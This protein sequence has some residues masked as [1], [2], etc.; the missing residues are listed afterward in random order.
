M[1]D[2]IERLRVIN[3]LRVALVMVLCISAALLLD[4]RTGVFVIFP[5]L[6]IAFMLHDESPMA[7]LSLVAGSLL[8]AI[9]SFVTID[10]FLTARPLFLL[11]TLIVTCILG[12]WAAQGFRGRWPWGFCALFAI[13]NV[14]G[15]AFAAI[16]GAELGERLALNWTLETALGVAVAWLVMLGIWPSPKTRDLEAFCEGVGHEC[17]VLLHKTADRIEAEQP[18]TYRPS[19]VSLMNFGKW[20]GQ[21]DSLK[22]RFT[23]DK[24]QHHA[25]RQR[26]RNLMLSY[27]NVRHL[28]RTLE[29][30]PRSETL[31]EIRT[32]MATVLRELANGMEH[33]GDMGSVEPLLTLIDGEQQ[34]RAENL[35]E[36]DS[37]FK[38]LPAK[39]AAFSAA[40]RE[41]RHD[42]LTLA[43]PQMSDER[44]PVETSSTGQAS[45]IAE[46]SAKASL[47]LSLGVAIALLFHLVP[48]VPA[49]SYLVLGLVIVMVQPNLGKSHLRVRL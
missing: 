16:G 39:L 24:Q 27:V 7:G 33:P 12:Y 48:L 35:D 26:L 3:A 15:A 10:L 25:I 47:K 20:L 44:I 28:E 31:A 29:E 23:A 30:F 42:I 49:G 22:W 21:V 2:Q 34:V 19:P 41:L 18:I 5:V 9:I 4:M 40:A 36:S 11:V 37:E 45:W 43:N 6:V 14:A 46:D 38:R 8:G 1:S 13:L 17:A 32:V